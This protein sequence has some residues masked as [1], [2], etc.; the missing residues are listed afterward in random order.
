MFHERSSSFLFPSS[1]SFCGLLQ[2]LAGRRSM[3]PS[4]AAFCRGILQPSISQGLSDDTSTPTFSS[5]WSFHFASPSRAPAIPFASKSREITKINLYDHERPAPQ[6]ADRE[7]STEIRCGPV[8]TKLR[9]HT[10][11]T[12]GTRHEFRIQCRRFRCRSKARE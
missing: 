6:L 1:E 8:T 4:A 11:P 2:W 9:Q 3:Q 10:A 12:E 5:L 7:V